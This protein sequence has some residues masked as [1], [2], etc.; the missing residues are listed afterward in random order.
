VTADPGPTP[1]GQRSFAEERHLHISL[2]VGST[3][4]RATLR[5][6]PAGRDFTALLP[7]SLTLRDFAGTEKISDLPSRLSTAEAPAGAAA[8]VGDIAYYAPWGNLAIFYRP[9]GYAQGLIVFGH[10]ETGLDHLAA[11]TGDVPVTIAVAP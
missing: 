10:L 1:S 4:H 7:L 2:T 6:T 8:D 3:A 9:S 5:D 11:A